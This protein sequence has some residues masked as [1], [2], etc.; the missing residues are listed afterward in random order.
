M[1]RKLR[2]WSTLENW[3]RAGDLAVKLVT[4]VAALTA[5]NFFS[6]RPHLTIANVDC[7]TPI[8]RFLL[9]RAYQSV[10]LHEPKNIA[11]LIKADERVQEWP[12]QPLAD[13][14]PNETLRHRC[15]DSLYPLTPPY[16]TGISRLEEKKTV[17]SK[18]YSEARQETVEVPAI[19]LDLMKNIVDPQEL[20]FALERV[21]KARYVEL[22]VEIHNGGW[23]TARSM[24]LSPPRGFK[25]GRPTGYERSYLNTQGETT[26]ARLI[27][28][29]NPI[30][31]LPARKSAFYLFVT[32]A[33]NSMV[34]LDDVSSLL[35]EAETGSI[36]N[37]PVVVAITAILFVGLWLPVVIRDVNR[38]APR[39]R[40]DS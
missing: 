30:V 33:G 3:N 23:G 1:L 26:E 2:E 28:P 5:I 24:R 40:N 25:L 29:L 6:T 17:A 32:A 27:Y 10:D 9:E 18:I 37:L 38:P 8:D 34:Q 7:R 20:K 14:L 16:T 15:L 39:S 19:A 13:R 22:L 36:V 4:I 11:E 12:F 21:E 31:D 35:P